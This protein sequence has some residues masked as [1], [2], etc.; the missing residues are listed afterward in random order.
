M[1][2]APLFLAVF[3]VIMIGKC[4]VKRRLHLI[5]IAQKCLN[6]NVFLAFIP[7][8]CSLFRVCGAFMRSRVDVRVERVVIY[9]DVGSRLL[10]N[11]L[12]DI[13]NAATCCT[14]SIFLLFSFELCYA[15]L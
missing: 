7:I 10:S 3:G 12:P 1:H 9:V 2:F 15:F 14:R 8:F 11:A 6:Y 4:T 13:G 5:Y